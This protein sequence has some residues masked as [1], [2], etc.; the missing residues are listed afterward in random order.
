MRIDRR[1]RRS[2]SASQPVDCFDR[3]ECRDSHDANADRFLVSEYPYAD[4]QT[5][6][7]LTNWRERLSQGN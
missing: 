3:S 5:I 1:A 6:R 7:V 4:G 2:V